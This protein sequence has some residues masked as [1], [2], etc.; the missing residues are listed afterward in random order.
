MGNGTSSDDGSDGRLN[1]KR[2]YSDYI[3]MWTS[4][5]SICDGRSEGDGK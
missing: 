4:A 5:G 2:L 3:K 1:E